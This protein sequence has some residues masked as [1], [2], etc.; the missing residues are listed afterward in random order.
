MKKYHS[1]PAARLS[2]PLPKGA[3]P[4]DG[5]ALAEKSLL[6]IFH[7]NRNKTKHIKF[8]C[9]SLLFSAIGYTQID[10]YPDQA[11]K[12]KMLRILRE[13][14]PNAQMS[15]LDIIVNAMR[16]SYNKGYRDALDLNSAASTYTG[17]NNRPQIESLQENLQKIRDRSEQ[18]RQEIFNSISTPRESTIR[19]EYPSDADTRQQ[20][21]TILE[22]R[23]AY[24]RSHFR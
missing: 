24:N 10:S 4:H 7:K 13:T 22:E 15:S 17:G 21:R 6:N 18:R 11:L 9:I 8:L 1:L 23:D 12:E 14:Q 2:E 5:T 20:V 16:K 3:K 19:I